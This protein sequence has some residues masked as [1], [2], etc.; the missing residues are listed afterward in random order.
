MVS[1][2]VTVTIFYGE[3]LYS[4]YS[5]LMVCCCVTV[6]VFILLVAVLHLQ[7]SYAVLLCY[8]FSTH[9]VCFYVTLALFIWFFLC[10]F[11]CIHMECCCVIFA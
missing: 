7:Y 1:Y 2:C 6:T 3:L 10:S 5:I 4:C 8:H 11:Y 9:M